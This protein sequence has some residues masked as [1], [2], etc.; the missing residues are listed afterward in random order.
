MA[1]QYIDGTLEE[2][3]LK[4]CLN[5]GNIVL[6]EEFTRESVFKIQYLIN[7]IVK[8]DK[9][10]KPKNK[11]IHITISSYGGCAYSCL[12]LIGMLENLREKEGYKIYTH[13]NSMAMSAGFFLSIVGDHRTANRYATGLIHPLLS[14]TNGSLQT[15]I[16]DMEHNETLWKQIE[17]ITL[18]YTKFTKEELDELKKCKRDKYMTAEE[19][20]EKGCIDEIL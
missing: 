18:R 15:M 4:S 3:K 20:L 14:S 12:S 10:K 8:M 16:E 11:E 2:M 5:D 6:I 7:K 9:I 1:T 13:I 17:D 19:M